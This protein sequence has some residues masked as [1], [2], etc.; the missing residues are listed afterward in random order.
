MDAESTHCLTISGQ[1]LFQSLVLST[2]SS[3]N[4]GESK[5]DANTICWQRGCTLIA[6]CLQLRTQSYWFN[7]EKRNILFCSCRL[8]TPLT[9]RPN[10]FSYNPSSYEKLVDCTIV[11]TYLAEEI[12]AD[13]SQ[14]VNHQNKINFSPKLLAIQY[15]I[16]CNMLESYFHVYKRLVGSLA[17]V[18]M[19]AYNM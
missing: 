13:C 6:C 9:F 18:C 2:K 5:P 3:S 17:N 19:Q 4:K 12:L 15:T 10:A 16:C 7:A 14:T 8:W 11:L 1:Y